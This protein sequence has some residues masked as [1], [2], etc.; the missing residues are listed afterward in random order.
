MGPPPVENL[1]LEYQEKIFVNYTIPTLC[2]CLV[3]PCEH[4]KKGFAKAPEP[5][6]WLYFERCLQKA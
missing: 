6:L 5:Q 4:I 3:N 2:N 1:F